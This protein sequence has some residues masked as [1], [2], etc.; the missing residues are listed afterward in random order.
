MVLYILHILYI[1][2]IIYTVIIKFAVNKDKFLKIYYTLSR[3][4]IV[5]NVSQMSMYAYGW[6]K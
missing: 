4:V 6:E 3:T 5:I 2:Y 1:T